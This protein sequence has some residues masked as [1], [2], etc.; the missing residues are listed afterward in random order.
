MRDEPILGEGALDELPIEWPDMSVAQIE[1]EKV[2]IQAKL[3]LEKAQ[4]EQDI[5]LRELSF[6]R[7]IQGDNNREVDIIKQVRLVSLG[8]PF[9]RPCATSKQRAS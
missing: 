6:A 5:W 4:I 7:N 1:L 8:A 9:I 3:E 2:K